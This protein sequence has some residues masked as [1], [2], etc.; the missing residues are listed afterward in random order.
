MVSANF[1][2]EDARFLLQP[3]WWS[4]GTGMYA[5]EL[6]H[7]Y[8]EEELRDYWTST[9]WNLLDLVAVEKQYNLS[10]I[11]KVKVYEFKSSHDQPSRIFEQLPG[12]VWVADEVWLVLGKKHRKPKGLPRWVGVSRYNGESFETIYEPRDIPYYEN[13]EF[14]SV[15]GVYLA[16][17]ALPFYDVETPHWGQFVRFVK[18]WFINSALEQKTKFKLLPY[19]AW[20]KALIYFL[21]NVSRE[22]ER[23]SRLNLV[24]T[25][26]LILNPE[27]KEW[28]QS[29]LYEQKPHGFSDEDLEKILEKGTLE[30]A[31]VVIAH[32]YKDKPEEWFDDDGCPP[33][34]SIRK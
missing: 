15:K 24:R 33:G 23:L 2:K 9:E 12:Y 34:K 10:Y 30:E 21:S 32:W 17:Y 19:E 16:K 28:T 5:D 20:E 18:K 7:A 8:V 1:G 14:K 3:L 11:P 6:I 26:E 25:H 29:T 4:E 27:K 31:D 13:S 22:D